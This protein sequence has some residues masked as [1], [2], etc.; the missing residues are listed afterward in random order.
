MMSRPVYRKPKALVQD[1]SVCTVHENNGDV[2]GRSPRR[3]AIV[4]ALRR[5]ATPRQ[6]QC[7]YLYYGRGLNQQAIAKLLEVNV[8]TVCRNIRNG[9]RHVEEVLEMMAD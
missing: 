4:R 2:V 3:R 8:S 6:R 7:L 9:E 1:L 5:R